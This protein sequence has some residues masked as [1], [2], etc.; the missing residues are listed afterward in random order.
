M[1]RKLIELEAGL[2]SN[3]SAEYPDG[4]LDKE[5][6]KSFH[7]ITEKPNRSFS[8]TPGHERIPDIWY[9]RPDEYTGQKLNEDL[10]TIFRAAP[11]SLTVG[12]NTG[13]VNSYQ[14]VDISDITGSAYRTQDLLDPK[15]LGCFIYQL[16]LSASP[17]LLRE[18]LVG[19]VLD[20]ALDLL[21]TNL[22][23][24]VDPQCVP[25]SEWHSAPS[26][27]ILPRID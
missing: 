5:T 16:Y 15:K 14:G 12:G 18:G 10:V 6:L 17:D 1:E 4:I 23:P 11:E 2:M 13:T 25:I 26:W 21:T 8:Y 27:L 24:L 3:H 19:T 22:K 7:A 20:T 9:R